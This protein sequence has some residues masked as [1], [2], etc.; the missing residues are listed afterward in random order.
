MEPT[1]LDPHHRAA[2]T[3]RLTTAGIRTDLIDP[4]IDFIASM[5]NDLTADEVVA[6]V[7]ARTDAQII[8][9]ITKADNAGHLV[10]G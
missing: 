9:A 8:G 6:T 7:S 4:A 5:H 1:D 3:D 2:L 10:G